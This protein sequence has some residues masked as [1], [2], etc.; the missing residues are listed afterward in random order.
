MALT[1][2]RTVRNRACVRAA[3]LAAVLLGAA[4]PAGAQSDDFSPAADPRVQAMVEELRRLADKAEATESA[5]PALLESLRELAARYDQP[6]AHQ[7]VRDTFQDGTFRSDPSWHVLSGDWQAVAGSVVSPPAG[8]A[9]ATPPPEADAEALKE[10]LDTVT[11]L[12]DR[13]RSLAEPEADAEAPVAPPVLP[14]PAETA[15]LALPVQIPSVFR[16]RT[17]LTLEDEPGR[18]AAALLMRETAD[19][20]T[21]DGYRLSITAFATRSRLTL[22]RLSALGGQMLGSAILDESLA[23]GEVYTV[24][25]ERRRDG[26]MSVM[27]NGETLVTAF[28]RRSPPALDQ[29]VLEREAGRLIVSEV[30]LRAPAS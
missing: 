21:R 18:H 25:L 10:K 5:D 1:R 22:E 13:M 15:R 27:L 3:L 2:I 24:A 20:R 4:L 16:L 29:L 9:L 19:G 11:R 23:T 28:D 14:A 17:L 30:T 6:F 26:M 12:V 8:P 7:I